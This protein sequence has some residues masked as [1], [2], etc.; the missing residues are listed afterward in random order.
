M[1]VMT[2]SYKETQK[3]KR[4]TEFEEVKGEEEE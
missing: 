3:N 1:L 4:L 2:I